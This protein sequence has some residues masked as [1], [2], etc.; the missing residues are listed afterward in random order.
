VRSVRSFLQTLLARVVSGIRAC[1]WGLLVVVVT[2][3]LFYGMFI[4]AK[5]ERIGSD[6]YYEW[7]FARSIVF[8]HDLDFANDYDLCG[9]SSHRRHDYGTGHVDNPFYI[10]PSILWVP[11]LEV[12][13]V[14]N[15]VPGWASL[16]EQQACEGLLVERTISM[17]VALGAL[18]VW[19]MYRIGR[20]WAGDG[21]AALAAGLLGMG[22]QLPAYASIMPSYSHVHDAFWASLTALAAIRAAERPRSIA[23]WALAGALVGIGMLQ[24]PVSVVYGLVPAGLAIAG[25]WRQP[26]RLASSLGAM[27]VLA[28]VTGAIPTMLLHKYF[29]GAYLPAPPEGPYFMWYGHAHPWL[30]LFAPHGGFFYVCPA[31]WLAVAGAVVAVRDREKR[32]LVL[33]MLAASAIAVWVCGA[34]LDWYESGTFGARRLTSVLPLIAAPT[35]LAVARFDR[36][37]RARPGRARVLLGVAVLVPVM[38][39]ILGAALGL[40]KN[41]IGTEGGFSQSELYGVGAQVSWGM[42]DEHLGDVALL[43]AEWVFHERYGVPMN[44]F[45]DATEPTYF[46]DFKTMGWGATTIDLAQT[47]REKLVTGMTVSSDGAHLGGKVGTTVFA[48]QW[49]IATTVEV[50]VR[51]GDP[52]TIRVGRGEAFGRTVWYGE[53]TTGPEDTSATLAIP[54]GGF[55]SGLM[56]I[57]FERVSGDATVIVSSLRFDDTNTYVPQL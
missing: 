37:L 22:S 35:A 42:L 34:A 28:F 24:R 19:I 50:K 46:R 1:R 3:G 2:W 4:T 14:I 25:L 44:Q 43:P 13:R 52:A 26:V 54:P 15:R 33:L 17:G 45:R 6:G 11:A 32:T 38:F 29:Y 40:A 53:V 18:T 10:G 7:L 16:K 55:D 49:P 31:A 23:R 47:Q 51:K 8:D 5:N 56:E 36:W 27:G 20:R 39:T 12:E 9:D 21:P 48:A 57:V 41:R 30:V